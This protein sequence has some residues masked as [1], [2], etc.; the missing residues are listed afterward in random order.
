[1]ELKLRALG[2]AFMFLLLNSSLN[3]LAF[4]T[5]SVNTARL[6]F[7]VILCVLATLLEDLCL[8]QVAVKDLVDGLRLHLFAGKDVLL[9]GSFNVRETGGRLI[10]N[11]HTL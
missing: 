4:A 7:V 6:T 10:L 11:F 9:S 5:R 1:M 3:I 2:G 8:Q